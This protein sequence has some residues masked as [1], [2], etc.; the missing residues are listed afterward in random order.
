MSITY[1]LK[2]E[3]ARKPGLND[4]P[5]NRG[6]RMVLVLG[7]GGLLALLVYSGANALHTLRELHEAEELAQVRSL[8]R[9]RVLSTVVLSASVYSNNM[10]EVLLGPQSGG[11]ADAAQEMARRAEEARAAL[12]AYP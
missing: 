1:A 7:F 5:T 6:L 2:E 4:R 12:M 9:G 11:N 3:A 8:E 10:E